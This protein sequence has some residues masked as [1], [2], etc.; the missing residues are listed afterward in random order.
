MA[1]LSITKNFVVF[2]N[3]QAEVF[4]NAIEESFSIYTIKKLYPE[5]I[6]Y[7]GYSFLY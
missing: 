5:Y 2:G 3:R 7:S 6:F 4:A 1:T